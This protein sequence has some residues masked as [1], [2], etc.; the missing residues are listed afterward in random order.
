MNEQSKVIMNGIDKMSSAVAALISIPDPTPAPPPATA[1]KA[2]E[3][4]FSTFAKTVEH[5]LRRMTEDD[6]MEFMAA[7][8]A[9]MYKPRTAY[10]PYS[11]P[12][13][14]YHQLGTY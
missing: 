2:V 5:R 12:G 11:A 10:P 14:S 8:T 3:D 7:V 9:L 13:P 4:E 6:A 1:P